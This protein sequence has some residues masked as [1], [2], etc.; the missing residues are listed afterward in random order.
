[1]SGRGRLPA[2]FISRPGPGA[3]SIMCRLL[4]DIVPLLVTELGSWT[5]GGRLHS[6]R[7]LRNLLVFAEGATTAHLE[8]LVTP[9]A[10]VCR[11]EDESVAEQAQDCAR[12]LGYF[13]DPAALFEG[14]LV[15]W[16]MVH[17]KTVYFILYE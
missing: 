10:L 13:V 2:P 12:L 16:F 7:M 9:L 8:Q 4:P 17:I 14:K 3:R 5:V 1:M 15:N 6:T 11:D